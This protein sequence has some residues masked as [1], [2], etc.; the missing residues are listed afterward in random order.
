MAECQVRDEQVVSE[1][2]LA[3]HPESETIDLL[4]RSGL[5]VE[6]LYEVINS[7]S[8]RRFSEVFHHIREHLDD[9]GVVCFSG[10]MRGGKTLYSLAIAF[11]I[12]RGGR[13]VF[14]KSEKDTRDPRAI[15]SACGMGSSEMRGNGEETVIFGEKS[16][17]DTAKR[18]KLIEA[19]LLVLDEIHFCSETERE[20]L[21]EIA[22]RRRELGKWTFV[23]LLD[24][25]FKRDTMR[26]YD[27]FMKIE[28]IGVKCMARCRRCGSEAVYSQREI[29]EEDRWVPASVEDPI[30]LAE[31]G[32]ERYRPHCAV[33]HR[34]REELDIA[35]EETIQ[36]R[37]F[38]TQIEMLVEE[39]QVRIWERKGQE[40]LV[41]REERIRQWE[42]IR[43]EDLCDLTRYE[44]ALLVKITELYMLYRSIDERW[45][46]YVNFLCIEGGI[47]VGKSTLIDL[48]RK[49]Y[50]VPQVREDVDFNRW[51]ADSIGGDDAKKRLAA[52]PAQ[53]YYAVTKIE[54]YLR[55]MRR[56]SM[57][58]ALGGRPN[59]TVV[60]DR[61]RW[62]DRVFIDLH[63]KAGNISDYELT[64]LDNIDILF[65]SIFPKKVHIVM[66]HADAQSLHRREIQRGRPFEAALPLEFLAEV[67]RMTLGKI[68]EL[69]LLPVAVRVIETSKDSDPPGIEA[70]R[71]F[72]RIV[73]DWHIRLPEI[74]PDIE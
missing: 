17:I 31:G 70:Y 23:S 3:N 7:L 4:Q 32:I 35:E 47:A 38:Y 16:P 59:Y 14:A 43:Y 48:L 6:Y 49:E 58:E 18:E 52:F 41:W 26:G 9:G 27:E 60:V 50:H 71:D 29:L 10:P 36:G 20:A 45:R 15:K 64:V 65:D 12:F 74:I 37:Q 42:R 5:R 44:F 25:D 69:G 28:P 2:E 57:I 66:L 55:E 40:Y 61:W 1:F 19:D 21:V 72:M 22:Q 33:C 73:G 68:E 24:F 51:L 67:Q 39:L 56:I 46:H 63:H 8:F 11:S 13:I 62:G 30:V 54:D 34:N 53:I